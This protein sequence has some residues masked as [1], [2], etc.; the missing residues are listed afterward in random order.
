MKRL[1]SIVFLAISLPILAQQVGPNIS[2]TSDNHDF[3]EIQEANGNVTHQFEFTNTGNAPLIITNVH[4]SCGC[5]SSDY[6][7]EP[8][9]PGQKGFVSA[10][11]N[12]SGRP[13][14]FNKTI[15]ITT[16]AATPTTIVRFSGEVI[17][18]PKSVEDQYPRTIG[19]LNVKTNHLAFATISNTDIKTDSVPM[20]NLTSSNLAITFKSV[21]DH[22][23]I[24]AVPEVLKPNETG[25]IEV[26]YDATK[27]NDWGFIMDK[28]IIVLN[29]DAGDN[30]NWL[31]V[32]AS[33][34]EDFSKLSEKELADA[35]KIVFESKVFNFGDIKQGEK[36]S[37]QFKF[38]NEGKK[39]LIIRKTKSSCG[40][41]IVNNSKEVIKPG[42]SSSFDVTFNSS[43]KSNRQNKT[44]SIIT[45]DPENS[46]ISLR[47][48]GNIVVPQEN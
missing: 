43:G 36:A 33:I 1:I 34:N 23:K 4:P 48:T 28:I 25:Y 44:I 14:K 20:A 45:N 9:A 7:K 24:K 5:T 15:T 10:T 22:I 41:T 42:E 17:A 6:T 32:S 35:P 29:G 11:F 39:D 40:C 46:Q 16:N 2:W 8:V 30:R 27:K 26:T 13:G 12:P 19:T 37:Y 38:K 31:S 21:P 47:V 3:G 18:K